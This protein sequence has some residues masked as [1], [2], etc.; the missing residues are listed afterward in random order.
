[1]RYNVAQLLKELTGSTRSYE[2]DER[3]PSPE[4][5]W[6]DELEVTGPVDMVRTPRGLLVSAQLHTTVE[7]TCARCL[8][9]AVE[10][11]DVTIEEE[12]FPTIDV[13]TGAPV[14]L[15]EGDDSFTIDRRHIVDLTEAFRQ[16]VWLARDQ[17]PLCRPDCKGLCPVC[18][19]NLNTGQCSCDTSAGDPRWD[20]LRR[21]LSA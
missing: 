17:Q 6:G 1:M 7:G 8:E 12:F 18:G 2:V 10:P 16:G 3:L 21:R 4:P 15:P 9:A 5:E 20:V 19:T 13:I 11:V 14:Q